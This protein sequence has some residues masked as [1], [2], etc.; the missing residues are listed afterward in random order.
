[1]SR[2]S[3]NHVL[4]CLV[5]L[6]VILLTHWMAELFPAG[7]IF[8]HWVEHHFEDASSPAAMG[9]VAAAFGA[10]LLIF[11]KLSAWA[12]KL[13]EHFMGVRALH[14]SEARAH[15]VVIFA[16][17]E[18]YGDTVKH[19]AQLAEHGHTE[20]RGKTVQLSSTLADDLARVHADE[21]HRLAIFQL[22][23]GLKP[24][25][26]K[27]SLKRAYL[28]CSS[29][30]VKEAMHARAII[31]RYAPAVAVE[32]R[33]SEDFDDTEKLRETFEHIIEHEVGSQ[34]VSPGQMVID[35]TGGTKTVSIAGTMATVKNSVKIQYVPNDWNKSPSQV[36]LVIEAPRHAGH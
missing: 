17:S 21:G 8:V 1:M 35:I 33:Q 22:L 13:G 19:L 2:H 11:I 9:I 32:V 12:V 26:L 16:V 4:F 6:L 5:A 24:H 30:S 27:G 10:L 7:H 3:W 23:R 15:A 14:E 31:N 18:H 28:V 34:G 25:L 20:V 36:D 29:R